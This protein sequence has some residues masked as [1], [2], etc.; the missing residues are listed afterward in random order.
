M[1]SIDYRKRAVEYKQE[2]HT[3]KEL[4]ETFL[5]S[6]ETYYRWVQE[7]ENGFPKPKTPRERS[8]KIDK[9]RLRQAV[10]EKP[11]AYLSELAEL[12]DCT[13]QAVA[14]MLKTMKITLKKRPSPTQ[15]NLNP[16]DKN[17]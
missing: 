15:K 4:K 10:E 13:F 1:Y 3:F 17:I 16:N 2:G 12:F 6:S 5:I 9:Q 14:K 7:Y 8:R 11:D